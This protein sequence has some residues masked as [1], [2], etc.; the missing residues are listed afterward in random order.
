VKVVFRD[1]CEQAHV[2][3]TLLAKLRPDAHYVHPAYGNLDAERLLALLES[4]RA[5]YGG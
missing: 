5:R 2:P 4:S 3:Q 1:G